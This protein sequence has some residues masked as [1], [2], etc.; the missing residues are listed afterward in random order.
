MSRTALFFLIAV[1]RVGMLGILLL[2]I[3]WMHETEASSAASASS[4]QTT[5]ATPAASTTPSTTTAFPTGVRPLNQGVIATT[6]V[7]STTARAAS[8]LA[9][10][11]AC[12]YVEDNHWQAYCNADGS[13][14]AQIFDDTECTQPRDLIHIDADD[15]PMYCDHLSSDHQV[16]LLIHPD[17]CSATP[18]GIMPLVE[19][20]CSLSFFERAFG[21]DYARVCGS[22]SSCP[23][24]KRYLPE[25]ATIEATCLNDRVTL[26]LFNA[27]GCGGTATT[28]TFNAN[29]CIDGETFGIGSCLAHEMSR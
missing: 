9:P 19:E 2:A 28:H 16:L 7:C 26:S 25:Y 8:M 20:T 6:G 17:D 11:G 5:S 18:M 22:A 12:M 3:L 23:S 13:I 29:E 10:Q 15:C 21:I 14:S 4:T 24:N 1:G 27:S